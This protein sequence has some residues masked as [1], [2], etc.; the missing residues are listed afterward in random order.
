MVATDGDEHVMD[1]LRRNASSNGA[2]DG[3]L[4]A[5][6][7]RWGEGGAL[8]ACGLARPPDLVLCCDCVYGVDVQVWTALVATL[9]ALSR[10]GRTL[11]LMAHGNGAAPGVQAMLPRALILTLTRTLTLTLTQP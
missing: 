6:P 7:L 2:R 5:C 4:R 1:L 10:G 3:A 8:E 9:T 11:I